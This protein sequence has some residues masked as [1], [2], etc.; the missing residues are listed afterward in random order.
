MANEA[1]KSFGL[2][3]AEIIVDGVVITSDIAE[4]L[5]L[6]LSECT[7]VGKRMTFF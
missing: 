1:L 4:V 3:P 7:R 6:L 5:R 2:S